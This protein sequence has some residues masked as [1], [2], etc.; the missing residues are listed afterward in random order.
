MI[1]YVNGDSNSTGVELQDTQLSWPCKLAKKLNLELVNQA[2]GGASNDRI[3]RI[4][5]EFNQKIK[6]NFFVIIGWTSWEREEWSV[7]L[8]YYNVNASGH[9][10]LPD[11][12][13]LKYKRWVTQQND[14]ERCRKSCLTHKRIYQLHNYYKLQKIPHL[15]FN[16]LMSF[17]FDTPQLNWGNNFLNP[18]NNDYS[19]YWYLKNHGFVPTAQYHH[20]EDAQ[21]AWADLLHKYILDNQ[22]L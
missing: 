9:S 5:N 7:N 20:L 4:T 8:R 10:A 17:S 14:D 11:E 3:L 22:L 15:F 1:L 6:N 19:Y 12:L 13:Q 16:A 2:Q 21:Q 18:Y